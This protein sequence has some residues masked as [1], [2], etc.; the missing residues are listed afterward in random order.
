MG[1]KADRIAT[2]FLKDAQGYLQ[3][4]LPRILAC[5][6]QLSEED[7]W[8]RPNPASN[9]AGNIVLHLSGNVRQWV[10]SGL[11]GAT[12][13]RERDLE[14]SEQGPIPRKKL[15]AQLRKT[16]GEAL[17]VLKRLTLKDLTRVH[18]IQGFR[19]TGL[20]AVSHVC[21]HFSY[22]T[23]Q[24][25]YLTKMKQGQDLHFTKLPPYKPQK[26]AAH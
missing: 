7:I 12:D 11:G 8:W 21:E 3:R 10:V 1:A 26:L 9:S 19:E 25:V 13:I 22:H 16:V 14:F 17:R 4:D 6:S 15:V 2:L 20:H 23:A 18:R 5:L 24:I